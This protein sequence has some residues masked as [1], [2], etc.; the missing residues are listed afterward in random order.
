M[1]EC[2]HLTCV[3]LLLQKFFSFFSLEVEF[4]VQINCLAVITF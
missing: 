2:W 4:L 1:G 3:I